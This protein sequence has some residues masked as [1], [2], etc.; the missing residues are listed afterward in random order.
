MY[1]NYSKPLKEHA[2]NFNIF[3]PFKPLEEGQK[4]LE[5]RIPDHIKRGIQNSNSGILSI[6]EIMNPDQPAKK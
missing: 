6:P 4:T 5:R 2:F 3:P 1:K